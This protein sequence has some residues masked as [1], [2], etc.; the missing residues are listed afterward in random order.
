MTEHLFNTRKNQ[1]FFCK[2]CGVRA[3]GVGNDTPAGR[4]R[5][6]S[7][8]TCSLPMRGKA[9]LNRWMSLESEGGT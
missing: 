1:H 6:K 4:K 3:F 5:R 7:S 9:R 2:H 8:P